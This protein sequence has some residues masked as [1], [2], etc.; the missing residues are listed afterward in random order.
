ML[1]SVHMALTSSAER[2]VRSS[3]DSSSPRT[4]SASSRRLLSFVFGPA[5]LVSSTLL[6]LLPFLMCSTDARPYHRLHYTS[7]RTEL[8]TPLLHRPCLRCA[9]V[10]MRTSS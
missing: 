6:M 9:G 1:S 2:D 5:T 3:A 8:P 10:L 7:N 4:L